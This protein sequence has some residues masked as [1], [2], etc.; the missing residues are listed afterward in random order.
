MATDT[1]PIRVYKFLLDFKARNDGNSPS[2]REIAAG[3][4]VHSTSHVMFLLRKL[5]EMDLVMVQDARSRMI[6]VVGGKWIPP[7]VE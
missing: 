7:E 1:A 3:I 5:E 4:G 6:H 2:V